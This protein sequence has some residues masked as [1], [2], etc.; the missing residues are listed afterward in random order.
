MQPR[1]RRAAFTLVELLVVLSVIMILA[2]L[3]L[4]A[5]FRSRTQAYETSCKNNLLQIGKGLYT[6]MLNWDR[7]LLAN[8][9]TVPPAVQ[10]TPAPRVDRGFDDLSMLWGIPAFRRERT[11]TGTFIYTPVVTECYVQNIN[12]YNC[13]T[14]RDAGGSLSDKTTWW[15]E[16]RYKRTGKVMEYTWTSGKYVISTTQSAPTPKPQLSYE[17]CGEF[18]PSMQYGAINSNKAWLVHDEDANNENTSVVLKSN[19]YSSLKLTTKSNHRLRGGNIL[20]LDGR[21]EWVPAINWIDRVMNGIRE[22]ERIT[23]WSMPTEL[24]GVQ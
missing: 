2:S 10:V 23:G 6:Y 11:T 9:P 22:W 8:R 3:T 7:Y 12:V 14:T 4:S 20:F 13:P 16:L 5:V 19:D 15:K 17:Y 21:A 24:L 18:N 1:C